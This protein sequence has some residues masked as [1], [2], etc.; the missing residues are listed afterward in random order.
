MTE[1][2]YTKSQFA[3]DFF[4]CDGERLVSPDELTWRGESV[5]PNVLGAAALLLRERYPNT[6][7]DAI[8]NGTAN[9]PVERTIDGDRMH[10]VA[11]SHTISF[12]NPY[13]L[14]AYYPEALDGRGDAAY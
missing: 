10:V 4:A 6:F 12:P 5:A 8:D 9:R 1:V 14:A 2:S 7:D 11:G 13:A 3:S